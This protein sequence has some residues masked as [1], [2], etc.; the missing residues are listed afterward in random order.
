MVKYDHGE[1][2]GNP[3]VVSRDPKQVPEASPGQTFSRAPGHALGAPGHP[4]PPHPPY[5]SLSSPGMFMSAGGRLRT[6]R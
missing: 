3:K 5:M 2:T 4:L 1:S 6:G